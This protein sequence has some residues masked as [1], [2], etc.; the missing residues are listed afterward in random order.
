MQ[1]V[2]NKDKT[3]KRDMPKND[4]PFS[5]SSMSLLEQAKL[6]ALI[7]IDGDS[8]LRQH[9][10]GVMGRSETARGARR[11]S[12]EVPGMWTQIHV[13]DRMEKAYEILAMDP[14]ATRPK[15]YGAAWPNY[16]PMTPGELNALRNEIF[17]AGGQGALS[18]WESEQ[19]RVRPQPSSAQIS[20]ME[21]ALRWSFE[22]LSE[23][24]R[25]ARAIQ[26]RSM[27]AAMG[28]DIRKRC[29]RQGFNHEIFNA[30]WQQ[31]LNI[32]TAALIARKVPVS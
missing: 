13:L 21:Q 2:D 16:N 20:R 28:A 29:E 10:L 23:D 18:E 19:N 4:V 8:D 14:A 26:L 25:L 30:D 3:S 31:A 6:S 15:A 9:L 5:M 24:P 27:W 7:E 32:I 17:Q 11:S 1:M 12:R 22:Y